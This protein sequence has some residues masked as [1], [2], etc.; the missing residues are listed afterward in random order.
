[1]KKILT[2]LSFIVGVLGAHAQEKTEPIKITVDSARKIIDSYPHAPQ[3]TISINQPLFILAGKQVAYDSIRFINP[4]AIESIEVLKGA[5]A[6]EVYGE[7][8]KSGAVI[9][10]LKESKRE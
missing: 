1:M 6:E 8:A 3:P 2:A 10:T 9:I 5:K 7:K 4:N